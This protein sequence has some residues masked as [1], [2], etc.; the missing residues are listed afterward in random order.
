MAVSVVIPAA[1]L[2]K[3]FGGTIPKQFVGLAGK[4]ILVHTAL[5][6][7][8]C[9]AVDAL[10]VAAHP[11][12]IDDIWELARRFGITKLAACV[13]GGTER[14][15]S[16]LQALATPTVQQSDIVLV[17]DAVRP[18]VDDTFISSIVQA[19]NVYGAVVPG[20]PP[21]ETIKEV[22]NANAVVRTCNR[23]MMR[24]VQTPQGFRR[25]LLH[26]AYQNASA[27]KFL[28]TDDASVVEY[29]GHAVHIV[30]GREENIKITTPFDM[31]IAEILVQQHSKSSVPLS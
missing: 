7:E 8:Q 14:Q 18:F 29:A 31:R 4:P 21:K 3:R 17:H 10:V 6:F 24:T 15:H 19:V 11:S 20:L 16:I 30:D 23:S 26:E 28:G 25:E 1:G 5:A 13:P 9:G 12:F 22:D 27:K 2:G